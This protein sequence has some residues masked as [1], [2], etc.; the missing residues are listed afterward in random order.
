MSPLI[1]VAPVLVMPAPART[2]KLEALPS[3]TAVAVAA[4]L[5]TRIKARPTDSRAPSVPAHA[6]SRRTRLAP[7]R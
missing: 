2:A 3:G 4:A 1:V 6:A 5:V 7:G